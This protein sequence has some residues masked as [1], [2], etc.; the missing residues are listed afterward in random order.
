[1]FNMPKIV[2]YLYRAG[3]LLG[4]RWLLRSK[5]TLPSRPSVPPRLLYVLASCLPYHISGYTARAHEILVALRSGGI[6]VRAFTRPGYPWDRKDRLCDTSNE[7]TSVQELTYSH[8][9]K[10]ANRLPL[11]AFAY[12]A[13]KTIEQ[14]AREH[15][16]SCIHA[17]SNHTNALPAL[18]AARRLGLPFQY[19]M[20]GLWELTRA[21][22]QPAFENSFRYNLGLELEGLVAS[23]ADKVFVISEQ[24]GQ[25]AHKRW[26]IEANKIHLLPN[27]VDVERIKPDPSC[28]IL[29]NTVGYAGSLIN[30][31]G[32]DTLIDAVHLLRQKGHCVY[33]HI[34]GDGEARPNLEAQVES[35][36]LQHL[37]TFWGKVTPEEARDYLK[38][39]ALVCIPRK[40]FTVCKVVPPI[41]LVEA[42]ALGKVPVV[43]DLPV[44]RDE[45]PAGAIFFAPD[46]TEDLARVIGNALQNYTNLN[47]LAQAGLAHVL[48]HRQWNQFVGNV[49]P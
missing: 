47:G 39:C 14:Y 11:L 31:E 43:P 26:G 44:F 27:C 36:G 17:A 24:L 9:R 20:R 15:R 18:I 19:E 28:T 45:C 5:A 42:F 38:S 21:S 1:M 25:F 33:L 3:T 6:D 13:S 4:L 23:Q 35:L 10:P 22:R 48:A 29:P 7:T 37:V 8:I 12:L 16:V 34:I 41:K 32:L 46:D 49:L 40:P 30:Y 2:P